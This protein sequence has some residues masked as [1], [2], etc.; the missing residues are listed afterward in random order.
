MINIR[1]S[2]HS[3]THESTGECTLSRSAQ[4]ALQC[5]SE[6]DFN[7][8][9]RGQR[10]G[11]MKGVWRQLT[12]VKKQ[13]GPSSA[14][15]G[16]LASVRGPTSSQPT[17]FPEFIHQQVT[18]MIQ[19]YHQYFYSYMSSGMLGFQLPPIVSMPPFVPPQQGPVPR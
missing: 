13:A 9:V 8:A 1:T 19:S 12:S 4:S 5:M 17:T 11:H 15:A 6:Y 3:Q 14:T 2:Q 10:R 18:W 16:S 7:S